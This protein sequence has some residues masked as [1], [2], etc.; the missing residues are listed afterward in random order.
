MQPSI[1]ECVRGRGDRCRFDT[2][3]EMYGILSG[4][5]EIR[6]FYKPTPCASV[7]MSNRA[8]MKLAGRCHNQ[9]NNLL[10]F[11]AECTRW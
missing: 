10:Y 9:A 5:G 8:A 11:K 7:P 6:T 2:L 4:K 1:L 3:T